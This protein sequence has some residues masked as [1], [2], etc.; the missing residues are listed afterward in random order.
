LSLIGSH[1]APGEIRRDRQANVGADKPLHD[2]FEIGHDHVQ[3]NQL[4]LERLLPAERKK[5][6]NQQSGA[7]AGFPR[8][9]DLLLKRMIGTQFG[10]QDVVVSHDDR[11]QI[12]E[13]MGD[14]PRK[15]S[16]RLHFLSLS[17]LFFA[18]PEG[19]F[20]SLPLTAFIALAQSALNRRNQPS[21]TLFEN[22][23]RCPLMER[24]DG[25]FIAYHGRNEEKRDLRC[26]L[27]REGQRA[28]TVETRQRI[29]CKNEIDVAFFQRAQKCLPA[30]D[31]LGDMGQP[32]LGQRRHDEVGVDRIIFEMQQ[33]KRLSHEAFGKITTV[34]RQQAAVR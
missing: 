4:G 6:T 22:I 30:V 25:Q 1:L 21:Q 23:I 7:I 24:V 16:D 19:F 27:T 28:D 9:F 18:L 20:R 14:P 12:I 34:L 31:T 13:V 2:I 10:R 29:V 3:G 33:A 17:Q 32:R 11:Q 15:T 5:L 26:V 8:L